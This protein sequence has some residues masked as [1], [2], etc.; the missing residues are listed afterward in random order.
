VGA[1]TFVRLR[2]A[3][4]PLLAAWLTEPTVARWWDHETSPEALEDDFGAGID[5]T[6]PTQVFLAW[7]E[8][9]PFGLIQRYAIEDYPEYVEELSAICALPHSAVS[10]DYLIGEPDCRGRGLGAAMIAAF[11]AESWAAYPDA[12]AVVV[13]MHQ[14]NAAS[15]RAVARAGFRRVAEGELTPDNPIDNRDHYVYRLDR[16]VP[17]VAAG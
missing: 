17:A 4:F 3:D 6:E 11:V 12:S 2:R 5:E 15:W 10:I 13:A 16:P 1:I 9:R 8:G 14:A 7:T